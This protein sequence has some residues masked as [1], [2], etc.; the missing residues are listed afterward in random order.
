M[1][2]LKDLHTEIDAKSI[3]V[4]LLDHIIDTWACPEPDDIEQLKLYK[5]ILDIRN[6]LM[7]DS[8][9]YA[10]WSFPEINIAVTAMLEREQ[11]RIDEPIQIDAPCLPR[12]SLDEINEMLVKSTITTKGV[13]NGNS[14][15]QL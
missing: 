8:W 13:K 4:Q 11:N 9:T 15:S 3:Q 7:R 2:R 14:I 12:I 10:G 5:S 1:S 6:Y